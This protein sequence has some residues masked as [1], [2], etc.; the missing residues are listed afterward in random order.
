MKV[1]W[2]S[3]T[4]SL[5]VEFNNG[6]NG[7]G[8]ISSLE[9]VMRT[10]PDFELGVAFEFP[11]NIFK[12]IHEN[13]TYYPIN[14]W[15]SLFRRLQKSFYTSAEIKYIMPECLKIIEDFKPNIIQVFGSENCFS[16][17]SKY[18]SVPVIIHM[19]GCLPAYYNAK[20]PVGVGWSDI[21]LSSSFSLK[22]KFFE[23]KN[24]HILKKRA[25]REEISLRTTSYFLGRT[26]WD[27][28][29]TRLYNP[30]STYFYCSEVLRD[31]FYENT[32]RWIP[33]KHSKLILVSVIS[34]P[35]YKGI[36]VILKTAKLLKEEGKLDL[37]WKVFGASEARFL[38]SHYH[39]R[40]SD[41]N[42]KFM[43]CI[44]AEIVKWELLQANYY[45]HPSYIDN[46]PNSVCEA[47]ILGIPVICCNVGGLSSLVK[48]NVTGFLVPANDPIKIADIIL[49]TYCN[50]KFMQQ[51]SG[52]EI[53]EAQKRHDRETIKK[54]LLNAYH[55]II[56]KDY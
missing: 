43:G 7:G 27:R 36:D 22:R 56:S 46:S 32:T 38:E 5:F 33:Q 14:V 40:A 51:I 30:R 37:E 18:T 47:Q 1:L 11:K 41:V 53:K 34:T 31:S 49:Q 4:P 8:W 28:S 39:I 35:L 50:N 20:Y 54:N 23:I 45:I 26:H 2:F 52:N 55:T 21:L 13:V 9:H 10:T 3:V 48:D 15:S 42:I 17:L 12:E 44:S 19:Q 24:S 29:I 6:H 25:Q 16:L